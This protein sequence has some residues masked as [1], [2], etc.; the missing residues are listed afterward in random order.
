MLFKIGFHKPVD[1]KKL[2]EKLPARHRLVA[3]Y[4]N[5]HE[6]DKSLSTIRFAQ[7]TMVNWVP[8][9]PF[10][11]GFADFCDMSF[12]ELT[13]NCIVY[14]GPKLLGEGVFRKLY[15]KNLSAEAKKFVST[16]AIE[17]LKEQNL[18]AQKF[19]GIKKAVAKT[20]LTLRIFKKADYNKF[21]K[22]KNPHVK[23]LMP[24]KAA[25]AVAALAIPL[26]EYS[27]NYV[28]NLFTLK[29]FKQADFNNIANLNK[30]KTENSAHQEKV[31]KS[32]K[33]HLM[34]AGG[35]FAGCLAF[36]TLLATKGRNSKFLTSVSEFILAPGNKI[37]KNNARRAAGFNKY[38]SIDFADN[39]GKLSLSRGQIASC[40]IIGGVGYFGAA[41]DRG[42]QNFL[43]VLYRFP[44]VGFYVITGS[45]MFE[46]AFKSYLRKKEGYKDLINENLEVP[47]LAQLGELAKKLAKRNKTSVEE[48]FNKLFKQK[49]TIIMV[50]LLFSMI[51]MGAFVAAMSRYFTQYR[52]NHDKSRQIND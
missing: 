26:C 15:S 12:L 18:P 17:L 50:P 9:I 51:G 21:A 2:I 11:R 37:F 24:I 23:E 44:L 25:I 19:A 41:K 47:K 7:D 4:I 27:L 10:A 16:P 14:I 8:K 34:F 31:R 38:F 48:E 1:V 52:Y 6:S 40:V 28:K 46:K 45:E 22:E 39:N 43:E 30:N 3:R 33:R 35:L 13:E 32:A 20:L 29:I 36:A 5:M 49:S 42:K